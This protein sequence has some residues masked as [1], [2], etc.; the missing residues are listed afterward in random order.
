MAKFVILRVRFPSAGVELIEIDKLATQDTDCS[1]NEGS[2]FAN[3][4]QSGS[5]KLTLFLNSSNI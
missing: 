2:L 3:H 4:V 1:A 5:E